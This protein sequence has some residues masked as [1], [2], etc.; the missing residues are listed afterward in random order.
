MRF[1]V[2][3]LLRISDSFPGSSVFR[4]DMKKKRWCCTAYLYKVIRHDLPCPSV[5]PGPPVTSRS[6]PVHP[7][8]CP[9]VALPGQ[10]RGQ[11]G[12]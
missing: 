6:S 7:L 10:T 4:R 5:R 1:Y 11:Q 9:L 2:D 3:V 12:H 8:V